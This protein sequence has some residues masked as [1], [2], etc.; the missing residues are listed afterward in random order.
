[1]PVRDP[2]LNVAADAIVERTLTVH[3][4]TGSPGSNGR[5]NRVSGGGYQGIDI[6]REG[7]T[8]AASGDVT[9]LADLEWPQASSDWGTVRAFSLFSG[10]TFWADGLFSPAVDIPNR[11]TFRINARTLVIAGSST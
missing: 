7:W 2:A 10:A 11:A 8:E 5:A 6:P 4:H 1:M 9:N 3:L